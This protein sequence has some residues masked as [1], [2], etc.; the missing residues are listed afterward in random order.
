MKK[1]VCAAM[2]ALSLAFFLFLPA[3]A[4]MGPKDSLNVLVK[5]APQEPYYLDLLYQ[6]APE[7]L[8]QNLTQENRAMLDQSLLQ[9]L[10]DARPAGWTLALTDGTGAPC[11]GQLTGTP[12]ADGTVLHAFSYF[13]LPDSYRVIIVTAS[14]ERF[15]SRTCTRPTLQSSLTVDWAGKTVTQPFAAL[16][17]LVQFLASF[18]PT[19]LLEG[20]VL[21]L[22]GF[23]LRKN[24]K[25]FLLVNLGTQLLVFL[26][27]GLSM[28]RSSLG[29][30]YY[31]LFFPVEAAVTAAETL[32]YARFLKGHGRK[33][34]VIYGITA[35]LLSAVLGWF[36]AVPV[37][38]V[39][40]SFL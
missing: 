29:F 40:S 39:V 21:V 16:A 27:L 7:S 25:V 30:S 38:R 34:A 20:L 1:A 12:Q 14:G 32:L 22:F 13:G 28:V 10:T 9:A 18:L 6:D 5:N 19:L 33:R 23:S 37:W 4:D 17:Y 36:L 24:G 15:I 2:A 26:V 35:N 3:T 11:F 31:L 8:Y